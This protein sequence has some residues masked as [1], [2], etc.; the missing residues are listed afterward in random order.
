MSLDCTLKIE[1][2]CRKDITCICELCLRSR[3]ERANPCNR[4]TLPTPNRARGRITY[5]V[6]SGKGN[7][8]DCP[9]NSGLPY[10]PETAKA[11]ENIFLTTEHFI[12]DCAVNKCTEKYFRQIS[13]KCS[14]NRGVFLLYVEGVFS[15][16]LPPRERR[17][18]AA[19]K[20]LQNNI[21]STKGAGKK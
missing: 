5:R 10:L 21:F 20:P 7:I 6:D 18:S 17:L 4:D 14:A 1:S 12:S 8:P 13:K 11:A 16:H 3:R 9:D 15:E 19:R 2:R